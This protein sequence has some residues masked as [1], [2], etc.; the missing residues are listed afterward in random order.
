MAY[1][2]DFH[3]EAEAEFD[4]AIAWYQSQ[5]DGLEQEFFEEYLALE[6][7]LEQN[8]HQF[9]T[10]LDDIRRANFRRFPYSLFFEPMQ[11]AVFI[12]AIFHQN[13]NPEE[14]KKRAF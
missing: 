10:V 5:R 13:R 1:R 7:R 14:W 8:P 9:P 11:A 4:E 2:L 6:T 3:P 12:Y